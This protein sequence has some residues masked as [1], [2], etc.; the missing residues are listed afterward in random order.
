MIRLMVMEVMQERERFIPDDGEHNSEDYWWFGPSPSG[1][2]SSFGLCTED[3]Y[4][5]TFFGYF[6]SLSLHKRLLMALI[7]SLLIMMIVILLVY[8]ETERETESPKIRV[9]AV[10]HEEEPL[11]FYPNSSF[12]LFYT[13]SL[14]IFSL[15]S[16]NSF[17]LL[18]RCLCVHH[19]SCRWSGGGKGWKKGILILLNPKESRQ[20][21][22]GV[23]GYNR[24][25]RRRRIIIIVILIKVRIEQ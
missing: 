19:A 23:Q 22:V 1:L 4:F 16:I 9:M 25:R 20:S 8:T 24:R 15:A 17:F 5:N 14:P 7:S 10:E 18:F 3:D 2:P 12:L 13:F 6:F 11:L 21:I